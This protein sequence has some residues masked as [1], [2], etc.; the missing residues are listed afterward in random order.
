M[1]VMKE[2]PK[3]ELDNVTCIQEVNSQGGTGVICSFLAGENR[4]SLLLDKRSCGWT[5]NPT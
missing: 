3:L 2:G 4:T 1:E 5:Q